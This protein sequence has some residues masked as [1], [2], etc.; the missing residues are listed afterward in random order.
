VNVGAFVTL[1]TAPTSVKGVKTYND[2]MFAPT[3]SA[4]K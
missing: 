2:F 3:T 1:L 4:Q